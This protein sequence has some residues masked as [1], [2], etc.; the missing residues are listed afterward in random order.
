MFGKITDGGAFGDGGSHP[1]S[2]NGFATLV[3]LQATYPFATALSDDMAGLMIQSAVDY[4]DAHKCREVLL[5]AGTYRNIPTGIVMPPATN[6]RLKGAG[7]AYTII[8]CSPCGSNP[9]ITVQGSGDNATGPVEDISFWGFDT[10]SFGDPT[11][12]SS[13]GAP[14]NMR[15]GNPDPTLFTPGTF[16]IR[17][18]SCYYVKF[19]GLSFQNFDRAT[20]FAATG[21]NYLISWEDCFFQLNNVGFSIEHYA[22]YNSYENMTLWSCTIGNNNT[23]LF[24]EFGDGNTNGVVADLTLYGCSVDYNIQRHINYFG[25]QSSI[26]TRQNCVRM[27]GGHMESNSNTS[28]DGAYG[29]VFNGGDFRMLNVEVTESGTVPQC[30]VY[31]GGFAPSTAIDHCRQS[32]SPF[33]WVN[34]YNTSGLVT[35]GSNYG[36]PLVISSYGALYTEVSLPSTRTLNGSF[37]FPPNY[38]NDGK[39]GSD[40]LILGNTTV[41]IP[42]DDANF[43]YMLNTKIIF[44]TIPGATG[45]FEPVSGVTITSSGTGYTFGGAKP[46]EVTLRKVGANAWIATGQM[47]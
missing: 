19:K 42:I 26:N 10:K 30:L 15:A 5:D 37:T 16:G 38:P 14:G 40:L 18:S 39:G 41:T 20:D 7:R 43:Y 22:A 17:V 36:G 45:A 11:T 25:A 35:G 24:I 13:G 9:G 31:H 28:G 29:R 32:I 8:L 4:A 27:I 12:A 23:G 6:T 34:V 44:S 21:N 3:A 47:N 33:P 2:A 46:A 1:A